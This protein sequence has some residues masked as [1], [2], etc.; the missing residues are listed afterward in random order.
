MVLRDIPLDKF[1]LT[2]GRRPHNDLPIDNLAVSGE[3]AA[4]TVMGVDVIIEDLGST[5]GTAV[6]GVPVERHVLQDNDVIEIG[7]YKLKFVNDQLVRPVVED[8]D[9]TMLIRKKEPAPAAVPAANA[10]PAEASEGSQRQAAIMVLSGPR[11]GA[12][13]DLTKSL[14]SFGKPGE[15]VAVITR[16]AGGYFLT[17]VGGEKYP[18]VN[19]QRIDAQPRLLADHDVIEISGTKMEFYFK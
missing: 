4:V 10:S 6:N 18:K 17:H 11:A 9:K 13:L 7:K 12:G 2:I 14:T 8:Y 1:R 5:N 19:D 16:R 3:H 15:Q